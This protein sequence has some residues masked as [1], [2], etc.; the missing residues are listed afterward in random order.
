LQQLAYLADI[1]NKLNEF[2]LSVQGRSIT[3]LTAEDEV[4]AV[5]LQLISWYQCV[6][7]NK[8]DGFN[9]MG[10]YFEE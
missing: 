1:F 8:F 6:Q 4:V 7:Q 9:A 2:N 10:E 3:M 5:K